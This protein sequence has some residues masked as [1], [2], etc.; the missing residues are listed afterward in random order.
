MFLRIRVRGPRVFEQI[1]LLVRVLVYAHGGFVFR[2]LFFPFQ[3]EA[4]FRALNRSVWFRYWELG[5]GNYGRPPKT[6]RDG[7][8]PSVLI[9]SFMSLTDKRNTCLSVSVQRKVFLIHV[10]GSGDIS[11][12]FNG[13]A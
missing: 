1:L 10:K 3:A 5:H 7:T 13:V 6:C 9:V 12:L 4:H 8:S 2:T 11:R